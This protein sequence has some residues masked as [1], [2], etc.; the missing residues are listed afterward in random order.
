MA[1]EQE[2]STAAKVLDVPV[3]TFRDFLK[4][5]AKHDLWDEVTAAL[6]SADIRA[7]SMDR[8]PVEIIS[9]LVEG[10]GQGEQDDPDHSEALVTPECG[11]NVVVTHPDIHP[12]TP[13]GG[14]DAGGGDAGGGD[15]GPH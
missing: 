1:I 12:H 5:I 9:R 13:H 10:K 6:S 2:N 4:F 14:G 8:R 11:C 7:V 15:G 3:D